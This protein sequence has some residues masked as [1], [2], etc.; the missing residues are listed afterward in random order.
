MG[1]FF[2]NLLVFSFDFSRIKSITILIGVIA[3]V[4]LGVLW[5]DSK[6]EV[7]NFLEPR[8]ADSIEISDEHGASTAS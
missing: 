1:V 3:A 7:T 6:W 8:D 2:L 5:I 4:L